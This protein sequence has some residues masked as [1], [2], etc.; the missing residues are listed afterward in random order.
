MKTKNSAEIYAII[1]IVCILPFMIAMLLQSNVENNSNPQELEI[2]E[3]DSGV[4][5]L[6][7]AIETDE[8][9]SPYIAESY[10]LAKM[11]LRHEIF[12][13][14]PPN[15]HTADNGTKARLGRNIDLYVHK[16]ESGYFV[17]GGEMPWCTWKDFCKHL[18][19]TEGEIYYLQNTLV[20]E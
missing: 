13:N 15:W 12:S 1:A 11:Y 7:P 5:T 17:K 14:N 19:F 3:L 9:D 2:V 20:F 18:Q 10:T 6:I 8:L 4:K 16:L